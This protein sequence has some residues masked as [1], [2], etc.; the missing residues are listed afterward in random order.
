MSQKAVIDSQTNISGHKLWSAV[1]QTDFLLRRL[2][3]SVSFFDFRVLFF[4][5]VTIIFSTALLFAG[6]IFDILV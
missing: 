4:S 1:C 2:L 5:L 3:K 6:T